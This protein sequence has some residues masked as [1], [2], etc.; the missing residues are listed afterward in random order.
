[1]DT[2]RFMD[3]DE[4]AVC[5]NHACDPN[6]SLRGK[7][8]LVALRPI[9]AGDAI[10]FDYSLTIPA[11]NPWVMAFACACGSPACRGQLGNRSTVPG[12][13][14]LLAMGALQDFIARELEAEIG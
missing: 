11:S 4:P 13:R 12:A 8:D 1:V 6:A 7:A 10:T 9:R 3:L 2:D 5:F 14:A